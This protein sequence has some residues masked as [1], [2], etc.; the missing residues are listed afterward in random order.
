MLERSWKLRMSFASSLILVGMLISL[1]GPAL[2]A[3]AQGGTVVRIVPSSAQIGV[4]DTV[5]PGVRIEN[6]ARHSAEVN[7]TF[8]PLVLEVVDA[9]P[10][11]DGVQ[12]QAGTFAFNSVFD[13]DEIHL[14]DNDG[15]EIGIA[16]R[17]GSVT[18]T[19]AS[20]QPTQ[21]A[22]PEAL[23]TPTPAFEFSTEPSPASAVLYTRTLQVWPD[24]SVGV[25]SGQLQGA[26]ASAAVFPFGVYAAPTGEVIRARTY[27]HFPLDVF[28]PGAEILRAVLHVYV[29][30]A[31]GEGTA[32]FGVYRALEP[33]GGGAWGT[34]PHNWPKLL[35]S[36]IALTTPFT[37]TVSA[38]AARK[39]L[40][41]AAP[42]AASDSLAGPEAG[43]FVVLTAAPFS[44]PLGTSVSPLPTP[45][46]QPT[47]SPSPALPHLPG[48]AAPVVPLR[49]VMGTWLTWDVTALA[50][51][52]LAGEVADY[53]LALA[54]APEPDAGPEA[55]GNL[56]LARALTADDPLTRPYLIVQV[57][58]HP[59]TPTPVP[60]VLLPRAGNPPPVQGGSVALL[61]A[62]AI[63][64][65]VGLMLRGRWRMLRGQQGHPAPT[66]D[67]RSGNRRR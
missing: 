8:D 52:W 62:G 47:A 16:A 45:T 2:F 35:I 1:A 38:A 18:V 31:A 48:A 53:G 10:Y 6:V 44:S 54:A 57:V 26:P 23:S 63:L 13:R 25:V 14:E 58:V 55:A 39:P 59:V 42:A 41:A 7:L 67:R 3:R 49:G 15:G 43:L 60:V 5:S 24:R 12:V 56:L 27:L 11:L 37:F 4:G 66:A 21:T 34:D 17:G 51:A 36:P 40:L 65:V 46:P 50:R 61:A 19:G 33:W 22:T 9:D 29:D 64:L 28:P 30:S 32:T 20:P